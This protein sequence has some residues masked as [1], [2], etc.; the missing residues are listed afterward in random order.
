[1]LHRLYR[2][3]RPAR[4][5]A[6][7]HSAQHP[8]TCYFHRPR[9]RLPQEG[10]VLRDGNKAAI[11]FPATEWESVAPAS[12]DERPVQCHCQRDNEGARGCIP[13]MDC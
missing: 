12:T 5:P 1:M 2:K 11:G 13:G 9:L 4:P 10:R 6:P 8:H 3:Q 7:Q